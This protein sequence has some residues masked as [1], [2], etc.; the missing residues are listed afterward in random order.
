MA[1][2]AMPPAGAMP[3]PRLP[4]MSCC[5]CASITGAP[6]PRSGAAGAA[7]A[8]VSFFLLPNIASIG[9]DLITFSL[10]VGSSP[11]AGG[12]PG[13]PG[14]PCMPGIPGMPCCGA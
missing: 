2:G 3:K 8:A 10:S 11:L 6:V 12:W 9:F 4:S 13:M 14:M 7:G 5:C 1:A